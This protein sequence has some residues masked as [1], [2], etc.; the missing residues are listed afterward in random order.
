MSK[1]TA[2]PWHRNVSSISAKMPNG[3]TVIICRCTPEVGLPERDANA[4]LIMAAP[5]LL[6]ACK[7][8]IRAAQLS[9]AGLTKEEQPYAEITDSD[10]DVIEAAIDKAEG[11]AV[12]K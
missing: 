11:K 8:I 1:H 4:R 10:I 3:T 12:E 7:R 6:A 5:D 2:G 9:L